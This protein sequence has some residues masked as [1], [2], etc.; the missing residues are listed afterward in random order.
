MNCIEERTIDSVLSQY[1]D[2]RDETS[3]STNAQRGE[4]AAYDRVVRDLNELSIIASHDV[5]QAARDFLRSTI[6]AYRAQKFDVKREESIAF[7]I[8]LHT[9]A[10]ELEQIE[11]K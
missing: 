8:V 6:H 10:D 4:R 9:A 2:A 7:A 1:R 11:V 5:T 3:N